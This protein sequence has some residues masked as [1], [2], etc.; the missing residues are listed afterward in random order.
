MVGGGREGLLRKKVPEFLGMG[1]H[2]NKEP[3]VSNIRWLQ[4]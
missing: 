1:L 2:G 4:R 3:L